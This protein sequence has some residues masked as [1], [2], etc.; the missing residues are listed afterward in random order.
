MVAVRDPFGIR[1]LVLGRMDNGAIVLASE[2]C[3]FDIIDAEYLREVLPGE[4]VTI[5]DEGIESRWLVP[6]DTIKPAYCIFEQIYF[7]NPAS[8]VFCENVHQVRK[9]MGAK[10][11]EEA[12]VDA[13]AV[14][15]IPNCAR[16]AA[17]GYSRASGIPHE[18]GFVTSHYM[19]RSFIMP[20]QNQR[21]VAVKMKLNVLKRNVK[22]KRLVV[23]EDSV[24]R[25]TTTQGKIGALRK[26]GAKEI[27]LRVASPPIRHPCYFGIDFP[28]AEELI[29]H[30]RSVD[31][32]RDY[33]GVDSL[34]YLSLD[35]ML[36]CVQDDDDHYCTACFSGKYP[37][38]VNQPVGKFGLERYQLQMFE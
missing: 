24:V 9:A 30:G 13:D 31:Q 34:H 17:F 19:G 10:L 27:H 14:V 36:S 11:A 37:M 2:T 6:E 7:A 3:A 8:D 22:G 33:L 16:C 23:V 20:E 25:G 4:V 35:G 29:A 21:D 28:T 5:S 1:P 18:R 12:P 32:I 26:A 15:P 38:P